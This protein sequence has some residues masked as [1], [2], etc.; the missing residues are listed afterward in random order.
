MSTIFLV[1]EFHPS[2]F[3][4]HLKKYRDVGSFFPVSDQTLLKIEQREELAK[5]SFFSVRY[6]ITLF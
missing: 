6:N 2:D 1:N 4:M 3:T 5:R